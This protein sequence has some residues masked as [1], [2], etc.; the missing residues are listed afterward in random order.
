[1]NLYY[2]PYDI[3]AFYKKQRFFRFYNISKERLEEIRLLALN[4]I[5]YFTKNTM[6]TLGEIMT[7]C[8]SKL[9]TSSRNFGLSSSD[10]IILFFIFLVD[11]NFLFLEAYESCNKKEDIKPL[12]LANFGIY[13]P[14]LIFYEVHFNRRFALEEHQDIW[15]RGL[16][17]TSLLD[18]HGIAK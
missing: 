15:A 10:E 17:D 2:N 14:Y 16:I 7:A 3:A 9:T 5:N 12:C 1:M 11:P 8:A 13:D 18:K 6:G 4:N